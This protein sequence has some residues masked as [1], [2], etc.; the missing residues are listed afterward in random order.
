MTVTLVHLPD[1]SVIRAAD[2]IS[3]TLHRGFFG[4]TIAVIVRTAHDKFPFYCST[5]GEALKIR[6]RII[7]QWEEG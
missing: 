3:V 1:G 7:A 4:A 5:M 6:D 2:V